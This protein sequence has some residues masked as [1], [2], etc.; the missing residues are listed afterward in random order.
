MADIMKKQYGVHI[1]IDHP[2]VQVISL[3]DADKCVNVIATAI[4]GLTSKKSTTSS[5]STEQ[6]KSKRR[7]TKNAPLTS[8]KIALTLKK[9]PKKVKV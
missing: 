5:A 3:L 4:Q 6:G 9:A 8:K 2:N 1:D 7:P